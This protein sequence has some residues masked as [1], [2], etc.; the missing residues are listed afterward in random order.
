[1]FLDFEKLYSFLSIV[2]LLIYEKIKL[3]KGMGK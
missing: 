2:K 3:I 1:M